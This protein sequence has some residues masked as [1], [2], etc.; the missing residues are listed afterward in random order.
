[1]QR[2]QKANI[3]HSGL[4]RQR[5]DGGIKK[6]EKKLATSRFILREEDMNIN[7]ERMRGEGKQ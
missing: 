2:V 4:R 7:L 5:D 6:G 3:L 1:M